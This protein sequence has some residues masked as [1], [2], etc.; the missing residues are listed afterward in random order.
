MLLDSGK[1][2]Q[3][4]AKDGVNKRIGDEQT[5]WFYNQH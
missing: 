5:W 3:A 1:S 4:K 2:G